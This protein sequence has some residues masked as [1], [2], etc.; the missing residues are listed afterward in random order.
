M[1]KPTAVSEAKRY[2]RKADV[3]ARYGCTTRHVDRLADD[4]RIPKPIY[5]AKFPMWS[6][7]ELAA[8][9]RAAVRRRASS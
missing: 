2:L 5:I 3:A 6:E 8:F 1:S 4:G 9:E 7:A